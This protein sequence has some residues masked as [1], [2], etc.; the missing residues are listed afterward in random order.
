MTLEGGQLMTQ[1]TG[2]PKFP[3]Y[4]ESGTRFFLKVVEAEIEFFTDGQGRG[5]Y[6][7]IHQGGQDVK[8]IKK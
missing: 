7:V 1:M 5:D 2:Q 3:V 8:A 4:A 6:L